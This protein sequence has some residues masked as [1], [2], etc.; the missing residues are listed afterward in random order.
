MEST[1]QC[2]SLTGNSLNWRCC[3]LVWRIYLL[4]KTCFYPLG[5]DQP[6]LDCKLWGGTTWT[7]DFKCREVKTGF[8]R[9]RWLQ[10]GSSGTLIGWKSGQTTNVP[11]RD[12]MEGA[13]LWTLVWIES[14]HLP[15]PHD[16]HRLTT[17]WSGA[18]AHRSDAYIFWQKTSFDPL[19]RDQSS[20]RL[21]ALSP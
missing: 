20:F 13:C 2:Y 7:W 21:P 10:T 11:L 19:G 12:R 1:S 8:C 4:T 16:T 6:S 9:K 5:R 15:S 18:A 3:S 14:T 17:R